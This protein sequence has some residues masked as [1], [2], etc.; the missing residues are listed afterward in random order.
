M[1]K[2]NWLSVGLKLAS[3]IGTYATAVENIKQASPG[4]EK[5]QAVLD[6][7][8]IGIITTE[9][10]VEKDVLNDPAVLTASSAYIDAYVALQNAISRTKA[11][12]T[13]TGTAAQ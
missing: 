10:V 4:P 7:V 5:K 1:A 13:A 8:A 3:L 2:R 12:K 11:L 9:F 6:A